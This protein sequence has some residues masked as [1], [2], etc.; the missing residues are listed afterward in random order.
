MIALRR[1]QHPRNRL[2]AARCTTDPLIRFF[3][4]WRSKSTSAPPLANLLIR[5]ETWPISCVP[6][7]KA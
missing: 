1:R 3:V 2:L 5:L 7:V 4:C 6:T